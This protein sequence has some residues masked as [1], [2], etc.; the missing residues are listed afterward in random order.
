MHQHMILFAFFSLLF[1]TLSFFFVSMHVSV[2]VFFLYVF[3]CLCR[4]GKGSGVFYIFNHCLYFS[5]CWCSFLFVLLYIFFAYEA[6]ISC[7]SSFQNL[8]HFKFVA[9]SWRISISLLSVAIVATISEEDA[10]QAEMETLFGPSSDS[11]PSRGATHNNKTAN[12]MTGLGKRTFQDM[13]TRL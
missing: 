7:G 11:T 2:C 6:F 1:M 13:G 8:S 9:L 12:R 4:G 10:V 3:V 5:P